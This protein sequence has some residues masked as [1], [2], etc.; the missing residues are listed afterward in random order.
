MGRARDMGAIHPSEVKRM[1]HDILWNGLRKD[2]KDASGHKYDTI[3]DFDSLRVVIRQ[4]EMKHTL[5]QQLY[6]KEKKSKP[7]PA[8]AAHVTPTTTEKSDIEEFKGIVQ[9]LVSKVDCY[10]RERQ[11]TSGSYR[12]PHR[13]Y[14]QGY[15]G[16]YRPP[17]QNYQS[18]QQPQ[19]QSNTQQQTTEQQHSKYQ[20]TSI[21]E[22]P[23][24]FRCGQYGH[25]KRGCGVNLDHSK[26]GLN[27]NKPMTR[28]RY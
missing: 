3:K 19:Q 18:R 12:E 4:I 17:R 15:R 27:F 21:Y 25:Y 28:G 16:T 13:G 11:Q 24:C 6:E 7:N 20:H 9:Q 2:F 22:E 5:E 14:Q 1:L 10:D 8:K 23:Q 26:K